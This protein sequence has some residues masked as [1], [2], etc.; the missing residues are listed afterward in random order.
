MKYS[1]LLFVVLIC[2]LLLMI[3]SV[4]CRKQSY[5]LPNFRDDETQLILSGSKNQ[6]M[7]ILNW[8]LQDDSLKLRTKSLPVH[9]Y[10]DTLIDYLLSRMYA[11]VTHPQH[12]G[13]GIAAI[14]VGIQKRLMWVKRYDKQGAP[15]E[16]Y[17]NPYIIEYSD[18]FKLRPD[19][20]LSIPGVNGS[21]Y[22]AIWVKVKYNTRNGEEV[23]EKINHEYTAH[24]FQH[25]I[26]HLDG[27]VWL[28]RRTLRSYPQKENI[29]VIQ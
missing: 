22:R 8:F 12:P 20:C 11:T 5:S 14:Q 25:E 21:S 7:R 26:D 10:P 27:I 17:L 19:G 23:I 4:Q 29:V 1:K 18:T 3:V 28:D 13:V 2:M 9:F 15:W 24:I 16:F 6:K